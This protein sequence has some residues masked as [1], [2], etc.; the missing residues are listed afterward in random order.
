[1]INAHSNGHIFILLKQLAGQERFQ[2]ITSIYYRGAVGALVVYDI[3]KYTSFKNT[4]K[5]LREL[6]N[7]TS[8]NICVMLVGNKMDLAVSLLRNV[9]YMYRLHIEHIYIKYCEKN[10]STWTHTLIQSHPELARG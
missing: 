4:E 5:W 9:T 8:E 6:H 1:M 2:A 10:A 7:N 3:T